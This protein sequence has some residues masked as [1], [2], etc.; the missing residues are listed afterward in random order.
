MD[1]GVYGDNMWNMANNFPDKLTVYVGAS[2]K[3]ETISY[4]ASIWIIQTSIWH[5]MTQLWRFLIQEIKSGK[6]PGADNLS[7]NLFRYLPEHDIR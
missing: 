6:L 2:K 4:Q 7:R 3:K 5:A 1:L